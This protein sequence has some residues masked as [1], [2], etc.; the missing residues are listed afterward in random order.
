MCRGSSK[1]HGMLKYVLNIGIIFS[2]CD[3]EGL[4][5]LTHS[6]LLPQIYISLEPSKMPSLGKGMRLMTRLLRK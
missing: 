2:F 5:F 4:F 1:C 3:R 6:T